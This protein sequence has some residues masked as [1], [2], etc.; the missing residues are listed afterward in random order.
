MFL[1][2]DDPTPPSKGKSI[3]ARL[4]ILSNDT[5]ERIFAGDGDMIENFMVEPVHDYANG[6][7]GMDDFPVVQQRCG[8]AGQG[9]QG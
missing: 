8:M 9:F 5:I 1:G 6:D 2:C 3:I 7:T 4:I